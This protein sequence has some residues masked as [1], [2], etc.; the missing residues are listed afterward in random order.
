MPLESPE[1]AGLIDAARALGPSIRAQRDDIEDSRQ[2]SDS[3]VTAMVDAGLFRMYVPRALGRLEVDPVTFNCVVEELAR[4]DGAAGWNLVVGAVYGA[5]GAF[6]REDVAREI[7]GGP[8]GTI[9][10]GPLNPGGRAI[11]VD[12]G[13][14]VTGRWVFGSGIKHAT[15]IIGNCIV[16][17]G[18]Q[19]RMGQGG[20][21]ESPIVIFPVSQCAI[22]DAWRVSGL[23]G[24]GSHDYSVEDLFVPKEHSLIAFTARPYQPGTLSACPF[25]TIFGASIAAPAL[26]MAR[27]LRRAGRACQRQDADRIDQ[28]TSRPPVDPV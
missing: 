5:F 4:I 19:K 23:R 14:Q 3:L 28:P 7:F 24:T 12:G 17:D 11:A 21:P 13:F 16:F 6:L 27:R 1:T 2:L 25:I 15:W 9:V 18:D 20:T 10:A 22:H 8:N 26:G